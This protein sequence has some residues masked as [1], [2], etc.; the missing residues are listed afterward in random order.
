MSIALVL[1]SICYPALAQNYQ[2]D[3]KTSVPSY[4]GEDGALY[5]D[6]SQITLADIPP[7]AEAG[8]FDIAQIAEST[9]LSTEELIAEIGYDPS[10]SWGAGTQIKDIFMLGD[11]KDIS[12]IDEWNMSAIAEAT[13]ADLG[14][15]KL[16]DFGLLK[17]L[18]VEDLISAVPD[19]ENLGLEEVEPL[20]DLAKAGLGVSKALS[21]K[22]SSL[23]DLAN[24][25]FDFASLKMDSIDL[26]QYDFSSIE[27]LEDA[28]FGDFAGSDG[29]MAS[30]VPYMEYV[31]MASYLLELVN[32]NF[33]GKIDVVYG[34]KEARRVNTISG[35]YQEGFN[36]PCEEDSCAYIELTDA[37]DFGLKF[38]PLHGKQWIAG[39]SQAVEGGFGP[40]KYANIT[41]EPGKEPTGRNVLVS[42]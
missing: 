27:G 40:L 28:Q 18:S 31:Q 5:P 10:R 30:E 17:D 13:G 12:N 11:F 7:I 4:V 38:A 21:L 35:S 42:F 23:G 33:I 6:W 22:D 15:L 36:V 34:E 19:L 3:S 25:N 24:S 41:P 2:I 37:I 16:E 39:K 20:F 14:G 8:S 29:K 1:N 32:F 26:S 9:G